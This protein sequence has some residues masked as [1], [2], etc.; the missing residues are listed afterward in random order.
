MCSN[1]EHIP[2]HQNILRL[3][4]RMLFLQFHIDFQMSVILPNCSY[5]YLRS[6]TFVC[7]ENMWSFFEHQNRE[8]DGRKIMN[9][10]HS[11]EYHAHCF[12]FDSASLFHYVYLYLPFSL[13]AALFLVENCF[14]HNNFVEFHFNSYFHVFFCTFALLFFPSW[15]FEWK[16]IRIS[17]FKCHSMFFHM[18]THFCIRR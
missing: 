5:V 4:S 14:Y 6:F 10:N 12:P 18:N 11:S 1:C 2:T 16:K 17:L 9:S 13:L 3:N 7:T 15:L 8:M